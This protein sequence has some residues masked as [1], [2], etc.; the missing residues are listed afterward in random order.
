MTMMKSEKIGSS[1]K[2][3][4][5]KP[6]KFIGALLGTII[7]VSAATSE[8]LPG[9]YPLSVSLSSTNFS[10]E[11]SN[12]ELSF[13]SSSNSSSIQSHTPD[14]ESNRVL[15]V[16]DDG[17]MALIHGVPMLWGINSGP[18][19]SL[20][21]LRRDHSSY[22]ESVLAFPDGLSAEDFKSIQLNGRGDILVLE[23]TFR[24]LSPNLTIWANCQLHI[25]TNGG[26]NW[27][28]IQGAAPN[29][30]SGTSD[31]S[32]IHYQL[33][34]DNSRITTLSADSSNELWIHSFPIFENTPQNS[35]SGFNV[36]PVASIENVQWALSGDGGSI[37][38]KKN[39][40]SKEAWLVDTET[41]DLTNLNETLPEL[42]ELHLNFHS[43]SLTL[44]GDAFI[45]QGQGTQETDLFHGTLNSE[46][47]WELEF[48]PRLHDIETETDLVGWSAEF[49]PRISADG[50]SA[51]LISNSRS[52][53][54]T[55]A[56]LFDLTTAAYSFIGPEYDCEVDF[57]QQ[58]A[59][60]YYYNSI[61]SSPDLK[62]FIFSQTS[63]TSVVFLAYT[64]TNLY[65]LDT[66]IDFEGRIRMPS[67]GTDPTVVSRSLTSAV[68]ENKDSE[69]TPLQP[70][71]IIMASGEQS[72]D[73]T[74]RRPVGQP[75]VE[76]RWIDDST[77]GPG[78]RYKETLSEASPW[79]EFGGLYYSVGDIHSAFITPTGNEF[80]KKREN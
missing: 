4:P 11:A 50:T 38:L 52:C 19:I 69:G 71:Y 31:F 53:L 30:V 60:D 46:G 35:Q 24:D 67:R 29:P 25:S 26:A 75:L 61:L 58:T 64:V 15:W 23:T 12:Q 56:H 7:A 54:R 55:K 32:L 51:L 65:Y 42:A 37:L 44:N 8:T 73:L 36:G 39:P 66:S 80:F 70:P 13:A 49:L 68:F 10:D 62:R 6:L 20:Y 41:G 78:L 9:I 17:S 1:N 43:Q 48:L 47:N 63:V 77:A 21:I 57:E 5:H 74:I 34:Q 27:E 22:R 59:T 72:E 79:R 40:D 16:S 28:I 33:S 14:H 45:I 3:S 18:D 76:L 2:N